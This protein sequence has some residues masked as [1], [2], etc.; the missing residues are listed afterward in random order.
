M[1]RNSGIKKN[2]IMLCAATW[3]DLQIIKL[4]EV[5]RIEKDKYLRSLIMRNLI[6]QNDA[7]A[8]NHKTKTNS[9]TLKPNSWLPKGK[10]CEEE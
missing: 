4:S 1:E 8:L 6:F 2:K 9:K 3:M 5:S 7:K 10:R